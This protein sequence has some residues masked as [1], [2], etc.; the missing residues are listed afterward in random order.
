VKSLC[1]PRALETFLTI[2]LLRQDR[3]FFVHKHIKKCLDGECRG[4]S[5]KEEAVY[6]EALSKNGTTLCFASDRPAS[7]IGSDNRVESVETIGIGMGND[8]KTVGD[9]NFIYSHEQERWV[10]L[11]ENISVLV[12]A[13]TNMV[14]LSKLLAAFDRV[15]KTTTAMD[16]PKRVIMEIAP[17]T[18]AS[19]G[20]IAHTHSGRIVWNTISGRIAA[21]SLDG[22]GKP[23]SLDL[24][25]CHE[26]TH[27][28]GAELKKPIEEIAQLLIKNRF[29]IGGSSA[30]VILVEELRPAVISIN[31]RYLNDKLDDWELYIGVLECSRGF[32]IRNAKYR[33][34]VHWHSQ[35]LATEIVLET[36]VDYLC[37]KERVTGGIWPELDRI[38]AFKD[39]A[40]E[41][42]IEESPFASPCRYDIPEIEPHP[43]GIRVYEV[44]LRRGLVSGPEDIWYEAPRDSQ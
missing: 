6:D 3:G 36:V 28:M 31:H 32:P 18:E 30:K 15:S 22:E 37:G 16:R 25:I 14:D 12:Q 39:I 29:S 21:V 10:G 17:D 33:E 7:I 11:S 1:F 41:S 2:N 9:W 20:T 44:G 38:L 24:M 42:P 8:I 40:A 26:I 34:N 19:P 23:S 13:E 4:V 35:E 5:R 27:L 43:K